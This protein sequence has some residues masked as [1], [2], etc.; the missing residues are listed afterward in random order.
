MRYSEYINRLHKARL[1]ILKEVIPDPDKLL[2]SLEQFVNILQAALNDPNI[3]TYQMSGITNSSIYTIA[4]II[5]ELRKIDKIPGR[6][7]DCE[8]LE[9]SGAYA[10]CNYSTCIL[11][12]DGFCDRF[13][14]REG[15]NINEEKILS[16]LDALYE[17]P[18][19]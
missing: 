8:Y 2:N 16:T 17:E 1:A 15:R 7:K 12:P 11:H 4:Y 14:K 10:E 9:V 3:S 6:C 19:K 18:T 5:E 13:R